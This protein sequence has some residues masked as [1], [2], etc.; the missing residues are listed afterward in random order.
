MRGLFQSGL[1]VL[2]ELPARYKQLT[3]Y[4]LNSVK[5]MVNLKY[6]T[7]KSLQLRERRSAGTGT[8]CLCSLSNTYSVK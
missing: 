3:T 7:S 2:K 6:L 1:A 8:R 4:N 5:G